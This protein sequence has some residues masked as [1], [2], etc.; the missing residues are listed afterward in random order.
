M[1][2]LFA[3]E[4]LDG[5]DMP[6][7][8]ETIPEGGEAADVQVAV[9]EDVSEIAGDTT[10]IDE[11]VGAVDQMEQVEEVVEA[12]AEG[13]GLSEVAAEAIKLA[14]EAICARVGANPKTVYNMYATENFGSASGRKAYTRMAL[15]GVSDFL[16]DMWK[17]IKAALQRLWDKA[18]KFW[19][20]HLSSLGRIKKALMSAR[21]RLSQTSGKLKDKAYIET[22]PSSMVDAFGFEKDISASTIMTVVK[23]HAALTQTADKINQEIAE[24]NAF[25]QAAASAGKADFAQLDR[26]AN[27]TLHYGT[28]QAPMVGGTFVTFTMS[29]DKAEGTIDFTVEREN[30][31]REGKLGLQLSDKGALQNLVKETIH[32]IDDTIRYRDKTK[33]IDEATS[34]FFMAM[35]K[36]LNELASSSSADDVKEMRKILKVVYKANAKGPQLNSELLAYNVKLGKAVLG[37]TGICMK[38]FK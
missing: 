12:A 36:R 5:G 26:L 11:G 4:N 8:M 24:L 32:V 17:K 28:A 34:K 38:H 33:K 30:A 20:S 25:A 3:L 15:E 7:E 35:E 10:A 31:E 16:K 29:S 13:E 2:K 18:R 9:D 6:A 21:E 19:D 14:V 27:A 22:A 37:Y 1:S 23:T